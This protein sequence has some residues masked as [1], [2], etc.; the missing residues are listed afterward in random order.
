MKKP[1]SQYCIA[2]GQCTKVGSSGTNEKVKAPKGGVPRFMSSTRTK[3]SRGNMKPE[4]SW[5]TERR[6]KNQ[7]GK[8]PHHTNENETKSNG[9][10]GACLRSLPTI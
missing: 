6:R 8:Q 4:W 10:D 9:Q 3:R 1:R 5:P 7:A 2:D